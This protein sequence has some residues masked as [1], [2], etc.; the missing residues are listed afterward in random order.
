MISVEP[1]KSEEV[2]KGLDREKRVFFIGCSGWK[3]L[4]NPGGE[5]ELQRMKKDLELRGVNF[6]GTMVIDALC[7]KGMD[8]LSLLGQFRQVLHSQVLLVMSCEVG[9]QALSI[10]SGRIIVPA[11]RTVSAEG[12]QGVLGGRKPADSAGIACWTWP[13]AS[14]P[15]ISVPR[16]C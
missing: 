12:L 10:T 15:C 9:V 16:L 5:P 11:L 6:T 7:N 2:L 3:S 4:C 1:R 13:A 14:A 8:E